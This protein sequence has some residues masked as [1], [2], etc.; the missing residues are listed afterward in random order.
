MMAPTRRAGI[1]CWVVAIVVTVAL[2][3][4]LV[5]LGRVLAQASVPFPTIV[6]QNCGTVH[7]IT[8]TQSDDPDHAALCLWRAYT[9]SATS[10]T[11]G[12]SAGC[13]VATLV[14]ADNGIDTGE[15]HVIT[16]QSSAGR[17][18]LADTTQAY[19]ANFRGHRFPIRTYACAT[20]RQQFGGLL[21]SGCAR[22][23]NIYIPAPTGEQTSTLCGAIT[24]A[25]HTVSVAA[26][27]TP[28]AGAPTVASIEDCFWQ[29]YVSCAYPASLEYEIDEPYGPAD[30][31]KALSYTLYLEAY[32]S[33][34]CSF[35][36]WEINHYSQSQTRI[37]CHTLA[38]QPDG[39][40]MTQGCDEGFTLVIPPA[41]PLNH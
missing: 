38:R 3:A 31:T 1:G 35:S 8:M 27:P 9:T 25:N 36:Y 37:S 23:R 33:G 28:T 15:T 34:G 21:L 14:F 22:E 12:A 20:L 13:H 16:L 19:S 18:A 39:G 40:L 5:A 2:G 26:G 30:P 10:T 6:G 11:S 24:N 7:L 32:P 41:T 29:A 4:G 17:C